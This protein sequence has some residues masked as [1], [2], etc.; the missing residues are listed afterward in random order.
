MDL[1]KL[2][3]S[4]GPATIIPRAADGD[5]QL[6]DIARLSPKEKIELAEMM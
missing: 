6:Q 3:I 4:I 2:E 5:A 1:G